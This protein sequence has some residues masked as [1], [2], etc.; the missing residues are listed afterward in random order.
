MS[1]S[2]KLTIIRFCCAPVV[3]LV[4]Y[5]LV[6]LEL[7]PRPGS[8]ILWALFLF[9]AITD[10]LDGYCARKMNQ[11]TEIGKLM[12]PF[13]DIL[14]L[15]TYFVCFLDAGLIRVWAFIIILWREYT[16]M[17]IRMLLAYRR[18][19]LGASFVGKL[20]TVLYFAGGVGGLIVLTLRIWFPA[21]PLL[22]LMEYLSRLLFIIAVL[23]AL[24][25]LAYY[26][27]VYMGI[28]VRS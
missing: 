12:D 22:P 14:L 13:S 21:H 3:F 15:V 16:I 28:R 11:V 19:A 7:S 17:F 10:I 9:S 20:K 23:F 18:V 6:K 24:V 2:N 8:L 27:R 1:L 4:W 25:S 5:S 26:F